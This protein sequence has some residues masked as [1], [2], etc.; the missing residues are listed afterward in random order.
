MPLTKRISELTP[1]GSN[2]DTTDLIVISEVDAGSSSG[3]TTKTITGAELGGTASDEKVKISSADT[4]TGYLED[5]VT[6]GTGVTIT[7]QNTGANETIE[8]SASG[9]GGGNTIYTA[10]DT[11]VGGRTVTIGSLLTFDAGKL[12]RTDAN[13]RN[14]V[15]VVRAT[16]LPT[17]LVANTTYVIRGSLTFNSAITIGVE[18]CEIIGLDRNEDEMVWA[19]TGSFLRVTDVNF[20]VENIKFSSAT[21]GNSIL[22][23]VNVTGT[24]FNDGRDKVLRL[25]NV[26]FRGTYEVMEIQGFDLVDINNCL[27]FYIKATTFGCRFQDVSKL[28]ITSCEFIRWFDESTLPTPSGYATADMIILMA[29]NLSSFGAVNING[30]IIHP[31]QTQ[32]GIAIDPSSTTGFGTISSNAFVTGGLT[33][34]KVFLPIQGTLPD[35]SQTATETYDVFANQGVLNSTSGV[36]MTL[37]GNTTQTAIVQ[38]VPIAINTGGGAVQQSSV[39]YTSN[40]NGLN[41]Y[42]GSKMVYVSIHATISFDKQGSG[43]DDYTFYIYKNSVVLPG[44]QTLVR[45]NQDDAITMTYGTLMNQSDVIE[46][47]VE[48]TASNDA[49]IIT[50]LQLVI[51][52]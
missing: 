46:I 29:N 4:T 10:D 28:Q 44:S 35:Y 17:T 51:R 34:G 13:G 47:Y 30:C 27:F 38:N 2:V 18:G 42:D 7:K 33:T 25:S 40:A 52:E 11:I 23:C 19:G 50:D 16:D 3:Y 39:R 12:D 21:S 6:A 32:N 31:Q 24:G 49:I 8:I 20:G 41:R 43:A 5:K 9:G 1:K 36:V 48:N 26:Q 45:A 14:I 22:K 15:E 37:T